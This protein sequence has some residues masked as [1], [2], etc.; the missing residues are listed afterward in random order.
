MREWHSIAS[1]ENEIYRSIAI[2]TAGEGTV[3]IERSTML[4][5]SELVDLRLIALAN[6]FGVDF[7]L[8]LGIELDDKG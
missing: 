8:A 2:E 6:G 7:S 1:A 4:A 5:T 3:S